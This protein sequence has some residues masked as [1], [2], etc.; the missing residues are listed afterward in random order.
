MLPSI[1]GRAWITGLNKH[2]LD[3]ADPFPVGYTLGDIWGSSS[4]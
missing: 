2:V 3:A 1:D 4:L